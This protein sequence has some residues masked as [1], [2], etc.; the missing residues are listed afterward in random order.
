MGKYRISVFSKLS[1]CIIVIG[2]FRY[3]LLAYSDSILVLLH[4]LLYRIFVLSH[5]HVAVRIFSLCVLARVLIIIVVGNLHLL[6]L[7][8]VVLE[9]AKCR[10][11]LR[12]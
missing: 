3:D 11:L 1:L 5:F 6:I 10:L 9:E 2:F 4:G 8:F 7:F 12:V